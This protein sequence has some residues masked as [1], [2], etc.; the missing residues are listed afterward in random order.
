VT[1][2]IGADGSRG[3]TGPVIHRLSP[4][5]PLIIAAEAVVGR[6]LGSVSPGTS[7]GRCDRPS[8][9]GWSTYVSCDAPPS[10]RDA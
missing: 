3:A 1:K 5:M 6:C 9:C 8:R 2:I 4:W 7:I 10:L